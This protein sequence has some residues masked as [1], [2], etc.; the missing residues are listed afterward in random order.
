MSVKLSKAPTYLYGIY[1]FSIISRLLSDANFSKMTE[2]NI[3]G[4]NF[5]GKKW[6]YLFLILFGTALSAHASAE[7]LTLEQKVDQI[8]KQS[9]LI[10]F[11][12]YIQLQ[13][14]R[15]QS[16][17]IPNGTGDSSLF[18]RR[19][20]LVAKGR[21]LKDLSYVVDVS[22][23]LSSDILLDA[24]ADWTPSD[25]AAFRLGQ[26]RIPFGIETQTASRK[27][28]FI[29]RMLLTNPDSEQ[30]SSKAV[31]SLKAGYIQERDL[32][33]R[34]SGKLLTGPIGLDYAVAAINGSDR[35][36]PDK[37]DKKDIVGRIGLTPVK[38]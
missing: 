27:L 37:N 13:Y 38:M 20:D 34:V 35:N 15:D 23:G 8:L 21:I 33:L 5:M 3:K 7:E 30:A 22:V 4:G 26:Y 14:Y 1:I 28:Y 25:M 18:P 36:N 32:G 6:I 11:G 9:D 29:D 31:S 10:Q 17:G 24:Y 2:R 19:V 16:T 12:A